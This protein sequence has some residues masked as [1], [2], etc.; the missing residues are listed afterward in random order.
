MTPHDDFHDAHD[1]AALRSFAIE[2]AVDEDRITA[3]EQR[4][5]T[6]VL[7]D[8]ARRRARLR[9]APRRRTWWRTALRQAPVAIVSAFI[10]VGLSF[11]GG[12]P[13]GE[14]ASASTDAAPFLNETAANMMSEQP[15]GVVSGGGG[16][17]GGGTAAPDAS[18]S[19]AIA[20][21]VVTIDIPSP[22]AE[23]QL[24]EAPDSQ[25]LAAGPDALP[26]ETLNT[27][28]A[29][30]SQLLQLLREAGSSNQ[31]RDVDYLPFRVA[32]SYV[33]SPNVPV[34]VRAAFLRMIGQL[35]GIDLGGTSSDVVGRPGTVIARLDT[36]SGIRQQYLL[37]PDNG[38]LLE[39]REFTTT[40]GGIGSCPAGMIIALEVFDDS[41]VVVD[42]QSAPWAPW[43]VVDPSCTPA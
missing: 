32:A 30:E 4:V 8:E 14:P 40:G 27:V 7:A 11:S 21:N 38:R 39:H 19:G 1:L 6:H 2:D 23:D 9:P 17:V 12:T 34:E 24:A 36:E 29:N 22:D 26:D 31:G 35:D 41:G 5:R 33:A 15:I 43:P 25:T 42:P 28:P 13:G 3:I 20:T 37:N 18:N 10:V 16:P